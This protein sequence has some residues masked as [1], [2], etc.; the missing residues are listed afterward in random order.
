MKSHSPQ[1][2]V[3]QFVQAMN[4]GDLEKALSL[5]EPGAAFV[6]RPGVV[7]TGTPALREALAELAMLKPALTTEA[8]EVVEAGDIALYCARWTLRGTDPAGNVVEQRGC[9]S[10]VLRRQ[11]DGS[12]RIALD[13][14]FGADIVS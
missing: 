9:S 11:A 12:W 8:R 5:Y 4:R 1:D 10:D 6:V 14:P 7:V 2:A 3:E 13:N